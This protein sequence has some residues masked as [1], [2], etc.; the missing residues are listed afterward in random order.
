MTSEP[1]N[2]FMNEP[3]EITLKVDSQTIVSHDGDGEQPITA[4][5][6]QTDTQVVNHRDYMDASTLHE[7]TGLSKSEVRELLVD[8]PQDKIATLNNQTFVRLPTVLKWNQTCLQS[9][10]PD[11]R[12]RGQAFQS[13]A[14]SLIIE[15]RTM[16][17]RAIA[18]STVLNKSNQAKKKKRKNLRETGQD[19]ECQL[20]QQP[21]DGQDTEVHHRQR[22]AD[23][24]ELAAELDNL[25]LVLI[26]SHREEHKDDKTLPTP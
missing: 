7:Q 10:D 4:L 6:V 23:K 12:A 26:P 8:T 17:A 22:V 15:P 1:E 20:S 19:R 11:A 13:S 25:A 16:K 21:I 3:R 24:P 2:N 18:A 14:H 5:R 9:S